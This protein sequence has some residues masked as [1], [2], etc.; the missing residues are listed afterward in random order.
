MSNQKQQY[1]IDITALKRRQME[2]QRKWLEYL[3]KKE[4]ATQDRDKAE[5]QV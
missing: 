3:E 1:H 5:T 4:P 2:G